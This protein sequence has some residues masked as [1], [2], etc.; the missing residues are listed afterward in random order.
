MGWPMPPAGCG[1][2][3]CLFFHARTSQAQLA[4]MPSIQASRDIAR[5]NPSLGM[6]GN[7]C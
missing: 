6:R 4:V 3:G 1:S 7:H 5:S 2:F